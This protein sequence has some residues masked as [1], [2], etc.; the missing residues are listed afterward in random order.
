MPAP[1]PRT[2]IEITPEEYAK[3][4]EFCTQIAA[5]QAG[6]NSRDAMRGDTGAARI[7]Q[8][9]IGKLGEVA[10]A[11]LIGG[12]VDFRVWQTGSRGLDQFEPDI[13]NPTH[14]LFAGKHVHVKTCNAKYTRSP[15]W[16]IDVADPVRTHPTLEDILVFALAGESSLTVD[17]VG[18]TPASNIVSL[19]KPCISS[20]MSHKRAVYTPDISG[21]L[22]PIE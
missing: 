1:I 9:V 21:H 8:G 13:S 18:W 19:W 10:V 4:E 16:T 20:S 7:T 12:D 2:R 11:K 22:R 17:I 14:K 3:V 15:S 6:R 5:K